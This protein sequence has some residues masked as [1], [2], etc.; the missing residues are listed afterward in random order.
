VG[1]WKRVSLWVPAALGAAAV[2]LLTTAW[3]EIQAVRWGYKNQ[4]LRGRLDDLEKRE[5]ALDQKL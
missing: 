5:A 4:A 2:L 3:F 1:F